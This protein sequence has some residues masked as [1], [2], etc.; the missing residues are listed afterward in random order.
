MRREST[1][2]VTGGARG[3][4][5][6]VAR[7]FAEDGW[8]VVV[9]DVLDEEGSR[10][11]A[12]LG[13]RARFAHL[14][15]T[16]ATDWDNAINLCREWTGGLTVLVNNAGILALGRIES[17]SEEELRRIV[18]VN[19][20]GPWL[21]MRAALPLLRGASGPAV[22]NVSSTAG[23][24][25]YAELG[26]YVAS[27]WALRGLT[28]TA[29]LEFAGDGIRV[30]SVHP[31]PIRT[32]MTE[33]MDDSVA[34]GQPIPRFGEPD[35]VARMVHFL[36][37]QATYSTGSEFLVDGGALAGQVLDLGAQG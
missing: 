33:E 7:V 30:C 32:P 22:V 36:A 9:A 31:G 17:Q 18:D 4:G 26:A 20:V 14:D 35:E 28:R 21:G 25:G 34:K 5:A 2:L 1:V 15:V 24:Q 27:K 29:A 16:S 11:A 3:I 37:G 8:A 6:A 10:T 13:D 19:L 12:A 23:M